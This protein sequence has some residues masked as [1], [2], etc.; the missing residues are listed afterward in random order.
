MNID[1]QLILTTLVILL[2]ARVAL[3]RLGHVL[4]YRRR[5][6]QQHARKLGG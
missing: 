5:K 1:L 3:V 6:A 4:H 2:V